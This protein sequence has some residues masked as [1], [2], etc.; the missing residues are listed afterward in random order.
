MRPLPAKGQ[1]MLGKQNA[2]AFFVKCCHAR[3]QDDKSTAHGRRWRAEGASPASPSYHFTP[4]I[5]PPL[6]L[7]P[8]PS[9]CRTWRINHF[10]T[11]FAPAVPNPHSVQNADFPLEGTEGI[12][13]SPD[14]RILILSSRPPQL[15]H[16]RPATATVPHRCRQIQ[17]T[18]D[19]VGGLACRRS[20]KC[21]CP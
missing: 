4:P 20:A 14:A 2:S 12:R 11:H 1:I 8:R 5:R 9:Y 3:Y 21:S 10:P 6:A 17:T 7:A 16:R 19:P 15:S 18:V 13:S